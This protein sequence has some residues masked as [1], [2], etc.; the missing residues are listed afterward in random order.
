MTDARRTTWGRLVLAKLWRGIVR[1]RFRSDAT[2]DTSD[3]V[4]DGFERRRGLTCGGRLYAFAPFAS[5]DLFIAYGL[6][7][8][9][10]WLVAFAF[11]VGR[12]AS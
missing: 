12:C 9:P 5:N 10:P 3:A 7:A 2:R 11:T 8:L 1:Q 4:R 6:T